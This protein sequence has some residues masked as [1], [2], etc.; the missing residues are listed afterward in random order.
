MEAEYLAGARL[1]VS[2]ISKAG[3][4]SSAFVK[5][6][7][8]LLILNPFE[9]RVAVARRLLF[10]GRDVLAEVLFLGLD[11]AD[12]GFIHEKHVISG[13]DVGLIFA[14]GDAWPGVEVDCPLVLHDPAAFAQ[15]Q[16]DAVAGGLLGIL[17]W[18]HVS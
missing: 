10:D 7:Q 12:G 17:I 14:N 9:L 8:R 5:E 13:A 1:R 6:R 15:H 2:G 11:D 3:N 4:H 18:G 16:I